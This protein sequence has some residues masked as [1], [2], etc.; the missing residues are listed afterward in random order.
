MRK[1][2]LLLIAIHPL[3]LFAQQPA[4]P[5]YGRLTG[6]VADTVHHTFLALTSVAVYS[7]KDTI[8]LGYML[9][10]REGR[11][12][13]PNIPK[14]TP[15]QVVTSYSGYRQQSWPVF[16]PATDSL[17]NMGILHLQR[18]ATDTLP[19]VIIESLIPMRMNGD[20]LEFNADAFKLAP[21]AVAEDLLRRLP[22]ITVWADGLI[23]VF[24]RPV[25][26]VLVDGKPFFGG[27]TKIATQNLDKMAIDKIQVYN[28][29]KDPMLPNQDSIMELNI[30]LKKDRNFGY[31][32]KLSA[33]KGNGNQYEA[34][35]TANLFNS[36]TQIGI[37]GAAN[38]VN[39]LATSINNL[40]EAATYKNNSANNSYKPDM[41]IQ[42]VREPFN[43]GLILQHDF[44][45]NPKVMNRLNSSFFSL[46]DNMLNL[47]AVNSITQLG[48]D[49]SLI[50]N[51]ASTQRNINTAQT[52]N[53]SYNFANPSK[54]YMLAIMPSWENKTLH[55]SST[56]KEATYNQQ[57]VLHTINE[58]ANNQTDNSN[59]YKLGLVYNQSINTRKTGTK[60]NRYSINYAVKA[61][62]NHAKWDRTTR[63]TSFLFPDENLNIGR[64]YIT[65]GNS[66]KNTIETELAG[67]L[68]WNKKTQTG[69]DITWQNKLTLN[70]E[71]EHNLVSDFN[72]ATEQYNKNNYLSN[73]QLSRELDHITGL[74]F[75]TIF[76]KNPGSI[77]NKYFS[78]H[79]TPQVQFFSQKNRSYVHSFQHINQQYTRFI[80]KLL[81]AYTNK[82]LGNKE[83]V[84]GIDINRQAIFPSI[85]QQV[86]LIDST[87]IFYLVMPNKH[88]N[89]ANKYNAILSWSR[90]YAKR[91]MTKYGISLHV[92]Q[93][94]HAFA[95]SSINYADGR[96]EVYTINKGEQKSIQL[97]GEVMRAIKFKRS[98]LQLKILPSLRMD[99]KPSFFNNQSNT[100]K[101]TTAG[102]NMTV[103]YT[104]GTHLSMYLSQS[105]NFSN[106][107]QQAFPTRPV[108]YATTITNLSASLNI[109]AKWN[110][111][112]DIDYRYNRMSRLSDISIALL[113]AS[114]SY[115]FLK[116]NN[117][118]VKL[119]A[120]DILKQNK[121]IRNTLQN[122]VLSNTT[123]NVMQQYFMLTVSYYPRQF[124]KNKK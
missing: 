7:K 106:A 41:V 100:I 109:T 20:T 65:T 119:A 24:G 115:R 12:S 67:R 38:N 44:S 55:S 25:Q 81:L 101:R 50:K 58:Q 94:H 11:F 108:K 107:K 27:I 116:G 57:G 10:D 32:G 96:T 82:L 13:I 8:L 15:L 56:N 102:G 124:G 47:T 19:E 73:H 68:V 31:F 48:N 34:A 114:T 49:S 22:G 89:P 33:G 105:I 111:N 6:Q 9:A 4:K 92:E 2:L 1:I 36:K 110:I 30:K 23:T 52:F 75:L 37:A 104:R 14:S 83:D 74:S 99:E 59:T 39:K 54:Q 123:Q 17:V 21:N 76:Y 51:Q 40:I 90:T 42:G 16:I 85:Q 61:G 18:S 112:S 80:P 121:S 43:A 63:Y 45:K 72:N 35:A 66:F 78:L 113:N 98:E 29:A 69:T 95:D 53:A 84:Y 26:N 91:N 62:D 77:A 97:Q 87:Q 5:V 103:H 28:R 60:L 3:L 93:T 88:L 120:L 122:N 64:N 71:K 46:S 79:V 117:I 118:E 70:R 86:G